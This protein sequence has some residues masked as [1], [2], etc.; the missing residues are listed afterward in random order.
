MTENEKLR[1]LYAHSGLT[2]QQ[3]ADLIAVP[4]HTIHA[5]LQ[6]PGTS[7]YRAMGN[8]CAELLRMKLTNMRKVPVD[9]YNVPAPE[10]TSKRIGPNPKKTP[11]TPVQED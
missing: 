3:I 1:H 5:W 11:A 4:L 9:V 8:C 10:P 6:K 2:R 7:N